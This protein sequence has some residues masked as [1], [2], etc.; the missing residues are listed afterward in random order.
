M[1][2]ALPGL[3]RIL[4]AE[5]T[6]PPVRQAALDCLALLRD[7]P[8]AECLR[9]VVVGT[10][11]FFRKQIHV[12]LAHV[13]EPRADAEPQPV[14]CRSAAILIIAFDAPRIEAA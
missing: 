1:R 3:E 11:A 4:L 14:G 7:G 8:R 6:P 10:A 2:A 9:G 12:D 5:S 13:R